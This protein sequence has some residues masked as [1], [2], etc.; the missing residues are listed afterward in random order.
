MKRYILFAA[1]SL[2]CFCGCQKKW[3]STVDLGVNNT[4]IDISWSQAQEQFDFV[5]PVYSTGA[6]TAE[7]VA[8]GDWLTLDRNSGTGTGYIHCSCLPNTINQVRAVKMEVSG[9]GKTITV[10][11]VVSSSSLAASDLADADLD[12]YLL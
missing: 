7:I 3:T 12:N 9:S 11:F 8:G 5:F 1:I 2:L 10:Y 4:R 6:W